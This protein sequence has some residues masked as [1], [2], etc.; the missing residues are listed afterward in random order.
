MKLKKKL[1]IRA[2]TDPKFRKL[3][4]ENPEA[5]LTKEELEEIK[6][7]VDGIME[8]ADLI[9]II[10]KTIAPMIFCIEPPGGG[11]IYA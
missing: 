11:P 6:G 1:V 5:A 2:L 7:G 10:S 9:D 8:Q 4:E 3:L